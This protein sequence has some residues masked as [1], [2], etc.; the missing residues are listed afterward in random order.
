[1]CQ[2]SDIECQTRRESQRKQTRDARG[3]ARVKV[4]GAGRGKGKINGAGQ[5]KQVRKST[6]L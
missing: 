1:M 5:G 4:C 2:H 3:G 6:D